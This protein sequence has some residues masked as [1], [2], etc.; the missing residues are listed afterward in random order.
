MDEDL[1]PQDMDGALPLPDVEADPPSLT[2]VQIAQFA[3]TFRQENTPYYTLWREC[4]GLLSN[5]SGRMGS[6]QVA[7]GANPMMDWL[8]P[9]AFNINLTEPKYREACAHLSTEVPSI[10][11]V[12]VTEA[13]EDL[14]KA[15]SASAMIGYHWREAKCK[16]VLAV[17][18]EW[19]VLH[20]T[21]GILTYMGGKKGE[22]VRQEAF[23]P[24]YLIAEPGIDNPDESRF[25]GVRRLT[26]KSELKRQFP[27]KAQEIDG[28]PPVNLYTY[29]TAG[30]KTTQLPPDR[31]EV[32][33]AYCRSGHSYLMVGDSGTVLAEG[34]T[35]GGC[36]PIQVLRYTRIPGRFWGMGMVELYAPIQYMFTSV[37][38]AIVDNARLM[39]N[40]KWIVNRQA[41]LDEGALTTNRGEIVWIDGDMSFVKQTTPSALPGYF[42]AL[43]AQIQSWGNDTTGFTSTLSGKRAVGVSSGRAVE[44]LSANALAALQGT[45]DSIEA[46]AVGMATC[47]LLFAKDF[48]PEQKVVREFGNTPGQ[49]MSTTL[50]TTNIMEDPQIFLEAGTLFS[51]EVKDRDAR[52]LDLLRAG[53]ITPEDAKKRLSFH[54]DPMSPVQIIADISHFQK[55]LGMVIELGPRI[56][57]ATGVMQPRVQTF[58]TDNLRVG[59]DVVGG[60]MQ[61]DAFYALPTDRQEAVAAFYQQIVSMSAPP[62]VPPPMGGKQ[63]VG[64]PPEPA[65]SVPGQGARGG[66]NQGPEAAVEHAEA[67]DGV[68]GGL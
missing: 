29:S 27:D 52:T 47:Y 67:A 10:G 50:D 16:E 49:A 46:G 21:A 32:L 9:R 13:Q 12:P 66:P 45:Q 17:A 41:R 65:M 23:R 64:A 61:D 26:T 37:T 43:P 39:G 36:M 24:E 35:P 8:R 59:L 57:P 15:R 6:V 20:G 63:P 2:P 40:P 33:E 53:I 25:L 19:M 22:D 30:F 4:S 44:A 58:P 1:P 38:N 62:A 3:S 42:E 31:V 11:V 34:K 60:Y 48:Y 14:K 56:D 5:W 7:A 51:M 18:T 68:T 55:L 54:L 28:A